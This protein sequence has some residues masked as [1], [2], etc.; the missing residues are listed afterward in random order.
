MSKWKGKWTPG[1]CQ[2]LPHTHTQ[3]T[4]PFS[5]PVSCS[6]CM[7]QP[8]KDNIRFVFVHKL[9]ALVF[10]LFVPLCFPAVC[11]LSDNIGDESVGKM[12]TFLVL[13][14]RI[15][16]S[17]QVGLYVLYTGRFQGHK[18]RCW[19]CHL[20]CVSLVSN[21]QRY[22]LPSVWAHTNTVCWYVVPNVALLWS[23]LNSFSRFACLLFSHWRHVY[24]FLVLGHC[25]KVNTSAELLCP[26]PCSQ[27][28]T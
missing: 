18:L 8:S 22:V 15:K 11:S 17:S 21:G 13:L 14:K 26:K 4:V 16:S 10:Y 25:G 19:Q 20:S 27:T 12:L 6:S 28:D 24:V 7:W 2:S 9:V 5:E 3:F 23:A 1:S